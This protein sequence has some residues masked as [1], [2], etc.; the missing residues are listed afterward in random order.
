M[1]EL[2]NT[3]PPLVAAEVATVVGGEGGFQPSWMKSL[4]IVTANTVVGGPKL[5]IRVPVS[6]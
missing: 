1:S 3:L 4:E 2:A 6:S 5:G